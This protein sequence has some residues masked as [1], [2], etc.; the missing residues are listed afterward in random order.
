MSLSL[1]RRGIFAWTGS[2]FVRPCSRGDPGTGTTRPCTCSRLPMVACESEA[3]E[4]CGSSESNHMEKAV[5]DFLRRLPPL[6]GV[7]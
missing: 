3:W 2:T 4:A 5:S 6:P 7:V 1:V